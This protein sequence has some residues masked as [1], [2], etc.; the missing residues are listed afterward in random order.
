MLWFI[1]CV[2]V[3]NLAAGFGLAVMLAG[4]RPHEEIPSPSRES[5]ASDDFDQLLSAAVSQDQEE[6]ADPPSV[7]DGQTPPT[8]NEPS[9]D[10]ESAVPSNDSI[11][12]DLDAAVSAALGDVS[13]PDDGEAASPREENQDSEEKKD[14]EGSR[15]NALAAFQNRLGSFCDELMALDDQLR[16]E[17]PEVSSELKARLDSLAASNQKQDEACKQVERSLRDMITAET[18]DAKQGEAVIAAIQGERQEAAET[19]EAFENVDPD[20]D[21][22]GQC[23]MV[24]ERTA[25]LLN[26]NHNLRD[27]VSDAIADTDSGDN[28]SGVDVDPLTGLPTRAG[29]DKTLAEHWKK[30]PHRARPLSLV[31]IDLDEFVKINQSHGPTVGDRVLRAVAQLLHNELPPDCCAAR[32]AGQQF[33]LLGIDRNLKQSVAD[34]ERLRQT[35]EMVRFEHGSDTVEVKVSCGVVEAKGIDTHKSLYDRAHE[36]LREAKRYGRNRCF[37]HEGE[38][39]T[40][41]VPP[42]FTISEKHVSL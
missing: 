40:P 11:M 42:N 3:V 8:E 34:A 29:L 5:L 38:F 26:A 37:M 36:S 10:S 33:V 30:D 12:T 16:E 35:I 7:D 24:L 23:E 13:L 17:P 14:V 2:A 19:L 20:A 31:L 21:V 15:E 1:L 4:D 25:S 9:E 27:S 6:E 28:E 32:F 22:S 41:V 18:I 39:P